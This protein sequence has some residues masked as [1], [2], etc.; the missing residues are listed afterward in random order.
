MAIIIVFENYDNYTGTILS[1]CRAL[2][3]GY[4]KTMGVRRLFSRG[5]QKHTICLKNGQNIL[6]S[7]LFSFKK[8]ENHNILGGQ[9]GG[10]KCPLMPSPAGAHD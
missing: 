1:E 10:G 5:G 8:V 7:T 6:F 4:I 2:K 9:G 3:F